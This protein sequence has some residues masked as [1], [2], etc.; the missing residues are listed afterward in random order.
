MKRKGILCAAWTSQDLTGIVGVVVESREGLW[1]VTGN[2]CRSQHVR[3]KLAWVRK[4]YALAV[5]SCGLAN[6]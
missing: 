2:Q 3:R 4:E 5:Y 1:G 6:L